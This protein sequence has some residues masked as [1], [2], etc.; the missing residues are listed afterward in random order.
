MWPPPLLFVRPYVRPFVR[1]SV[2]PSIPLP[3]PKNS[4]ILVLVLLSASVER[5]GV[6][7][8]R[9][10]LHWQYINYI[11]VDFFLPNKKIKKIILGL[12][13]FGK[14]KFIWIQF[15]SPIQIQIY[16]GIPK[17]G[18]YEYKYDY[19]DWYLKIQIQIWIHSTQNKL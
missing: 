1:L 18:Q 14:Y 11:S 6:S 2:R 17:L 9:E 10:F 15:F 12:L 8:V 4:F 16:F 13:F 19:S 7:N 3:L 5:F